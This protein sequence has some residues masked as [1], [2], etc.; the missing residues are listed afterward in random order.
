MTD[1][2]FFFPLDGPHIKHVRA[3]SFCI[4]FSFRENKFCKGKHILKKRENFTPV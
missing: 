4:R 2:R 1:S 3:H